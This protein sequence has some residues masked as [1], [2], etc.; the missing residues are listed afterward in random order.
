MAVAPGVALALALTAWNYSSKPLWRDEFYTWDTA[1]RSLPQMVALLRDNTDIGLAGYYAAMHLW[2]LVSTSAAWLR[3]PGAVASVVIAATVALLG[4][5]VGGSAVGVVAGL[6]AAALP[7]VT[8]HAQEA[9]PYPLVLAGV[10]LTVLAML[11]YRQ[12]PSPGH[13]WTLALVA[14]VP[15][16][17]HPIVGLPAVVGVFAAAL[18]APGRAPRA[19]VVLTSLPAA[20]VG[21]ALVVLGAQAAA[22]QDSATRQSVTQ[23]GDLAPA[24]VGPWWLSALV[25]A[26]AA[27]GLV[28]LHRGRSRL[29]AAGTFPILLG[30]LV[31]PFVVVGAMGLTGSFSEPR[32]VSAATVPLAVLAALGLV[33][34][35]SHLPRPVRTA[36][37][38]VTTLGVVLALVI[39]VAALR[40]A[41]FFG[42]DPRAGTLSLARQLQPGDAVAFNGGTARGL[43]DLYL[44]AGTTLDD[45]L[46]ARSPAASGTIWGIDAPEDAWPGLLGPHRRLWVVSMSRSKGRWNED[47]RLARLTA[48]RSMLTKESYG[49]WHLTLWVQKP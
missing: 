18:L 21:G 24:L 29:Q 39:P 2:L 9:R 42:D 10:S 1:R 33:A 44:P 13:A 25:W 5:R 14:A 49:H 38:G 36:A 26:A 6:L 17:L 34:G 47:P 4:R 11:R 35:A 43:T 15:G 41:P 30:A 8:I 7:A 22:R 31:A 32:Y 12:R 27:L 23:L 28:A 48:D 45:T 20:V 37:V 46:L 40:Q 3:L 19:G 16:L